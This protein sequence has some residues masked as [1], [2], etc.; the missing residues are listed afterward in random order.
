MRILTVALC[1]AALPACG[2]TSVLAGETADQAVMWCGKST[3]MPEEICACIGRRAE[4]DLNA[5]QQRFF[6]AMVSK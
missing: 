2:G 4:S 5:K 3:N 1:L 6:I